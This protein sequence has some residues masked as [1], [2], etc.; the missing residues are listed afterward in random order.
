MPFMAFA[1][2]CRS[3]L[4]SNIR[5][6]IHIKLQNEAFLTCVHQ[7]IPHWILTVKNPLH[8]PLKIEI[9]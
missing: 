1:V 3:L 2:I 5:I 8:I 6:P 7:E 9:S 4:L